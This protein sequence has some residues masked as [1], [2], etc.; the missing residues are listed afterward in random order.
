VTFSFVDSTSKN[1]ISY[2]VIGNAKNKGVGL[3]IL[4]ADTKNIGISRMLTPRDHD[5]R[6]AH[7]RFLL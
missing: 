5:I 1:I 7:E 3:G 6:D 2:Y 4:T